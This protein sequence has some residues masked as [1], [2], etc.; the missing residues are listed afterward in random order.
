MT[1]HVGRVSI[2]EELVVLFQDNEERARL[3]WSEV[4]LV[5][6][7]KQD[8]LVVDCIVIRLTKLS[9]GQFL[10]IDEEMV[11]YEDFQKELKRRYAFQNENWWREVAFPAFAENLTTIWK[12]ET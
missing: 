4:D 12:R 2:R 6:G 10:D 8:H 11:G 1:A 7:Y 9:T 3:A 5:Q